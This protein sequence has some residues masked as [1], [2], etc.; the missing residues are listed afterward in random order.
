MNIHDVQVELVRSGKTLDIDGYMKV[1]NEDFNNPE[2]KKSINKAGEI[3]DKHENICL[4]GL[5]IEYIKM[6]N[7]INN[8][9]VTWFEDEAT[10]E[11]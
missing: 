3:L 5:W 7:E 1:L 11:I 10:G 4:R 2:V 8:T 6:T 9:G